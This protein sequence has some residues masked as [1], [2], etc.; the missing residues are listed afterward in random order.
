MLEYITKF[1]FLFAVIDPIGSVP[2]YL[3]ATKQFDRTHKRK[4]AI[5]ASGV[6]F[7]VLLFFIIG[8]QL[9]LEGM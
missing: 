7:A 1:M 6:A 4:I 2:V 8:G 9:I 5:R 3:E